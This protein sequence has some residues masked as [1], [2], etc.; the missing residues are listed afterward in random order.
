[1]YVQECGHAERDG[2]P[3]KCVLLHNGLLSAHCDNDI[4]SYISTREC[5]RKK[6]IDH[7]GFHCDCAHVQDTAPQHTCCDICAELFKCGSDSC[8]DS[9]S[10][11]GDGHTIPE[12]TNFQ[13]SGDS[14]RQTRVVSN[15]ARKLLQN[16]LLDF[17]KELSNQ[18]EVESMVT[19][20]NVLLEFN[21]FH[22]SQIVRN[23]HL[24]FTIKDL[25]EIVEIWR[26]KYAVTVIQI[27]NDIFGDID[28]TKFPAVEEEA[29]DEQSSIQPDWVQL[30]DDSSLNLLIDT[31]DLENFF[32]LSEVSEEQDGSQNLE[33]SQD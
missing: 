26:L 1:M 9:W 7:F 21:S 28:T 5:R 32:S 24:I 18:G 23:C 11:R 14:N 16:R 12:V 13:S 6:L 33:N 17:H 30:R 8:P 27:L 25:T 20:P 4:K 19:C 2:L 22:I 10:P 3:S 31:N 15:A 29:M